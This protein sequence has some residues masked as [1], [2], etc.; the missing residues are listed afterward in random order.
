MPDDLR[1]HIRD[2]YAGALSRSE[3]L[4]GLGAA[5]F[6]DASVA[7]THEAASG[8][9]NAIIRATKPGRVSP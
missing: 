3:D 6:A 8:V 2:R 1:E 4:D 5:G 7:F 9:H